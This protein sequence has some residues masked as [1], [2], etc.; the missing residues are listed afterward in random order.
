MLELINC[1]CCCCIVYLEKSSSTYGAQAL[2]NDVE[3][4]LD[5]G[6]FAGH[7]TGHRH[8]RVEMA[9]AHMSQG[10]FGV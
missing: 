5:D 6:D 8:G 9:S 7:E 10:L 1:C 3:D 2:G 4:G